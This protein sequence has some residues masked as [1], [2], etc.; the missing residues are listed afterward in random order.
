MKYAVM[1]NLRLETSAKRDKLDNDVKLKI[2]GKKVWDE[3]ILGK[4]EDEEGYPSHSL[5]IRFY[6]EADMNELFG[7]IKTRM[8][9]TPVLKGTVSK[10]HC[11]HD[12]GNPQ[13][14]II[15]EEHS[16]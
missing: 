12:E 3:T 11:S 16:K 5:E 4:G 13:P 2:G 1:H 10:H 14:C 7:F 6:T 15:E 8:G 9:K